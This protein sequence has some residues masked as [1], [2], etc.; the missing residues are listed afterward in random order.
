MMVPTSE[1]PRSA[2]MADGYPTERGLVI[3]TVRR[4]SHRSLRVRS[5]KRTTAAP[6]GVNRSV[7]RSEGVTHEP[8]QR[9]IGIAT[10]A[11]GFPPRV[12][13]WEVR[14]RVP[15]RLQ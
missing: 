6:C 8:R 11:Q 13:G 3:G 7:S 10:T 1:A 9:S 5:L 2:W 15:R 12:G 4:T 14:Y